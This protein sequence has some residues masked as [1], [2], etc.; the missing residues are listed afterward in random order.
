MPL[1]KTI[2][3]PMNLATLTAM[4]PQDALDRLREGNQQFLAQVDQPPADPTKR[5][6]GKFVKET[7]KNG[8]FPF[9]FVLSCVDSRM[10]TELLFDQSIGDIFNARI[11]GNFVNGDILGSMEFA[12]TRTVTDSDENSVPVPVK[13]ILVLGHTSCGAVAGATEFVNPCCFPSKGDGDDG[14]DNKCPESGPVVKNLIQL[15]ENIAPAVKSTPFNLDL[16]E[17]E[18]CTD[19]GWQ[20]DFINRVARKNV[21]LTINNI[22]TQSEDIR[23]LSNSGALLIVGAMYDISTGEVDFFE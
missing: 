18:K 19:H 11:A 21:E 20:A 8:Q 9:A 15:L 10:P 23:N 1:K 5:N 17:N 12:C 16:E 3:E 13:L 22:M 14:D 4:T 2:E 6:L 7:S